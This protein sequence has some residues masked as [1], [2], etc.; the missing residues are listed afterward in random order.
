MDEIPQEQRFFELGDVGTYAD[1]A[2]GH[3]Y[4][5]NRLA[6]LILT[7]DG[8]M[9]NETAMDLV[10]SL[11]GDMPDDASDEYEAL[12]ILQQNTTDDASW[13]IEQ[14]LHLIPLSDSE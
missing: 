10:S 5:R 2:F 13:E 9:C 14:G 4:L 8:D 6:E 12:D 1:D 3:Q 11:E 7:L